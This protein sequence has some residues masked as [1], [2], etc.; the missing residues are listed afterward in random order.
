M[1]F[2]GVYMKQTKIYTARTL[3]DGKVIGKVGQYVAIP[4]KLKAYRI[5]VLYDGKEMMVEKW[6][7][8]DGYRKF[9]DKFGRKDENGNT[10][11]YTLGYFKW[12]PKAEYT[13]IDQWSN[14]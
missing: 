9:P 13:V 2:G 8:A 3:F 1:G 12:T 5:K 11:Q 10:L 6:L 14:E 7:N 4:N